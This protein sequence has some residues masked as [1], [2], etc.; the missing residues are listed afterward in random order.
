M[1]YIKQVPIY[2]IFIDLQ[3]VCN[4]MDRVRYL[5]ILEAYDVGLKILRVIWYFWDHAVLVCCAGGCYGIPFHARRGVTQGGPFSPPEY[6][7]PW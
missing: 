6:S 5:E 1:A 4:A 7:T 2:G 3:K